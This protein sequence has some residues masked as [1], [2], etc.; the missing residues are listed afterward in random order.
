MKVALDEGGD[1]ENKVK[2]EGLFWEKDKRTYWG[3]DVGLEE[4]GGKIKSRSL[5]CALSN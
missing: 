5:V 4:K 3:F 1:V 2:I